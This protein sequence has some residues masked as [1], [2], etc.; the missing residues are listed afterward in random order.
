MSIRVRAWLGVI[1]CCSLSL[2]VA[3]ADDVLQEL[4]GAPSIEQLTERVDRQVGSTIDGALASY[5]RMIQQQPFDVALRVQRCKFL[6]EYAASFETGSFLDE[7]YERAEQ[8]KLELENEFPDHPEVLLSKLEAT[9]GE[10]GLRQGKEILSTLL[11]EGWTRGQFARLYAAMAHAAQSAQQKRA[12]VEYAEKALALDETADVRMLLAREYLARG[13]KA[14]VIELLDT[15]FDTANHDSSWY[16]L[17]KMQLLS[18][19]GAPKVVAALYEDLQKTKYYNHLEAAKLLQ[20]AHAIELARKELAEALETY[21]HSAD[22][23][24]QRFLLELEHG[25]T[26]AALDAY[27]AWRDNGWRQDPLGANR[28]LLATRDLTLPWKARD[29]LALG[30][31]VG[32]LALV[33][34][35]CGAPVALVHYW[36]FIR[37]HRRSEPYPSGGWQLRHAWSALAAFAVAATI[38]LYAAAPFSF[39]TRMMLELSNDLAPSQWARYGLTESLLGV[40]AMIVVLRLGPRTGQVWSDHW[41]VLKAIGI[42]LGLGLALRIPLAISVLSQPDITAL[43]S[44]DELWQLLRHVRDEA[45]LLATLWLLAVAA[46]VVEEFIYRKVLLESFSAHVGFAR[47]NVLQ[48]ALFAAMHMDARAFLPLFGFGLLAAYL[49]RRSGGLVAPMVLHATFNLVAGVLLLK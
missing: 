40:I 46:P 47:A 11:Y 8:C 32:L 14:R 49:A 45:G 37:R 19:A 5:D 39:D 12:A 25:D 29:L 36:G 6:D 35:A 21:T 33:A 17:E 34:F 23:E 13:K 15:P 20:E 31:V 43:V 9:Y 4:G 30:F 27:N 44:D 24:R 18:R 1:A 48:A 3:D 22:D 7:L 2:A 41:S 42:G 28:I 26:A 16:L 38:G 10:E